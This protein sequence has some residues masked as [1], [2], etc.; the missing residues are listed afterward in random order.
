MLFR[1]IKSIIFFALLYF[2]LRFLGVDKNASLIVGLIPLILGVLDILA[3]PA[4]AITALVFVCAALSALLPGEYSNATDFVHRKF[5]SVTT[6]GV[7]AASEKP[8]QQ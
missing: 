3:A 6:D 1:F 2:S 8:V 4:F 7:Q 5:A